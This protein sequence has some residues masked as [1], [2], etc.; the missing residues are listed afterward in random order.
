MPTFYFHIRS[1]EIFVEDTE[2]AEHPTLESARR[3]AVVSA[4]HIIGEALRTGGSLRCALRWAFE[5]TDGDGRPVAILP[6]R[7]AAEVD[8]QTEGHC[9]LTSVQGVA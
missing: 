5:I 6:F 3:E 1:E 8:L 9:T 4:K 7:E 2:G